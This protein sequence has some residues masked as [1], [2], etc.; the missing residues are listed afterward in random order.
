MLPSIAQADRWLQMVAFMAAWPI[1]PWNQRAHCSL[2]ERELAL[3]IKVPALLH[4]WY[5]RTRHVLPRYPMI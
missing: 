4:D 1:E 2:A 5:A 3:G